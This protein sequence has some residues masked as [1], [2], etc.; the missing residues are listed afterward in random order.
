MK[1]LTQSG[2]MAEEHWREFLPR[3][4]ADLEANGPLPTTRLTAEDQTEAELDRIRRQLMRQGLTAPPADDSAW[5][6][7]RERYIFLPPEE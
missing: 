6:M 3:M 7:V 4:V 2:R 5:E 1:P